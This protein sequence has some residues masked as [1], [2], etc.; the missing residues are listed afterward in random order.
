[1]LMAC[2]L[3]RSEPT[4]VPSTVQTA[5]AVQTKGAEAPSP[6]KPTTRTVNTKILQNPETL[7]AADW[8]ARLTPLQYKVLREKGT[9]RAGTGPLLREKRKG[10]FHCAGCGRALY[11][12]ADKFN[13]G[14]GWPS[15]IRS[16]RGAV[17]WVPDNSAGMRRTELVCRHCDGHLGHVL[18]KT[19]RAS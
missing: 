6:V 16:I 11:R 8:R 15:F 17:R 13:S 1:M 18:Y 10:V 5:P 9:E 19:T 7:T 12:S 2:G 3:G 4:T 14:T